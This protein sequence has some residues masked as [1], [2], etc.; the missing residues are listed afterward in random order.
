M[1]SNNSYASHFSYIHKTIQ[2]QSFNT[3]AFFNIIVTANRFN[4]YTA[5]H[6][7]I[8]SFLIHLLRVMKCN[9]NRTSGNPWSRMS[10]SKVSMLQKQYAQH[11]MEIPGN[12]NTR[13]AGPISY[14][15]LVTGPLQWRHSGLDSVSNHQPR[16]CLL[17]R[18]FGRRSKKTSKIRV[19]GLCVG[20]STGTGE[21][22]AQMA[23]YAEN[24]SIWWRHHDCR[25]CSTTLFP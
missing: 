22:P 23:S 1:D 10:F 18:L 9:F 14:R 5:S 4:I 8:C 21:F 6:V 11:A 7:L 25:N 13:M 20:N 24:V 15:R 12:A 17:S 3:C 19:T 2:C 16:H